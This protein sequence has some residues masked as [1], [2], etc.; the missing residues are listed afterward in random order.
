MLTDRI[1]ASILNV[2]RQMNLFKIRVK[3]KLKKLKFY[4]FLRLSSTPVLGD[5]FLLS[6]SKLEINTFPAKTSVQIERVIVQSSLRV[7]PAIY[8]TAT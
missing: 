5:I 2:E 8:D 4:F 3:G 7:A 1:L 6:I